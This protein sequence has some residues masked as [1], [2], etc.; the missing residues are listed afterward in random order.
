MLN[1]KCPGLQTLQCTLKQKVENLVLR[2][3][4]VQC[5]YRYAFCLSF[6]ISATNEFVCSPLT[7]RV[8]QY[9]CLRHLH[10]KVRLSTFYD[11]E[12]FTREH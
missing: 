4:D 11:V 2:C 8:I 3:T 1:S 5:T 7:V 9:A 10:V 12:I 6:M